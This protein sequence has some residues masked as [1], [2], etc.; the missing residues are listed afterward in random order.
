MRF[1]QAKSQFGLWMRFLAAAVVVIAA[2]AATTAVA[3]LLQVQNVVNTLNLQSGIKSKYIKVPAPGAPQTILLIG[4]DHRAHEPFKRANTDTMLLV[5]LNA[6]SSTINVLSIPRDLQV[7]VPGYGVEK[8]NAAYS[9][10]GYDLLIQTIQNQVF[11]KFAPDHI[12]DVNFQGFSDLVDAIGCIYSDVDHRYYNVSQP[13]PSPDNYSS[14]DI[15]PGYQKLCGD[16]QS[17]KGALPFVRFRHTD[18]DLVR[19]AR[20]QDFLRWAKQQYPLS[21]AVSNEKR[22]LTIL[23]THSQ[24]DTKLHSLHGLLSLGNTLLNM[25]GAAIKQVTFPA[26]FLPCSPTAAATGA[27]A[28][29]ACDVASTSSAAV[30]AAWG[31]LMA[32]TPHPKPKPKS[33]SSGS[34]AEKRPAAQKLNTQGLTADLD[35]GRMQTA[36]LGKVKMPIYFPEYVLPNASGQ[37]PYC[38]AT[39]A[40]CNN[41]EEPGSAYL[42]SYPRGYIIHDQQGRPHAAYRMT[43]VLNYNQGWL[44]GVQGTTWKHP[45]LLAS[46]S[47]TMTVNRKKLY[48]YKD[49]SRLTTVA[50]H[51][52]GDS[53]WISNTLASL[54]PNREMIAMAASLTQGRP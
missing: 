4:S 28:P 6:A 20:Q 23:S 30:N 38:S 49:G 26:Q 40:N 53:F 34:S 41:G 47:G 17:V 24:S 21:E 8:I 51:H 33:S 39:V 50:W 15:Q 13:A 10:G 25:N 11:S 31:R 12:V 3:G 9:Q 19:S 44:Y 54:I 36:A 22:L 52:D 43:L 42:H 37:P 29:A 1:W 32:V 14:I 16:N 27:P 5:R 18:S 35:D 46:P 45:P 48:L 2:V 7:S